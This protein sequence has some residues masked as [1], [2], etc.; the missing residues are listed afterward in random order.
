MSLFSRITNRALKAMIRPVVGSWTDALARFNT[1][2]ETNYNPLRGLTITQAVSYLEAYNRGDM[3]TLQWLY[4]HIEQT[5]ADLMALIERR[6]SAILEMD[7]DTKITPATRRGQDW[8]ETL[9][10]EQ[11]AA[12]LE[13]YNRIDNLYEAIEHLAMASFRGFAHCEMQTNGTQ[14]VNH[15]EIVDQWNVVRDGFRGDWKYNP[16][17]AA[18]NFQ[19][20]TDQPVLPMDQFLYRQVARPIDRIA[21]I[22]FI[23]MSMAEK[24]WT[25]FLEIYGIPSGVVIL[26]P[27]FAP[28]K[29]DEYRD[30]AKQIAEGGSGALP[31]GSDYK[32]ND[33]PRGV[34]PFRAYLDYLSE[35]LVLAGTGGMLTMLTQSG[36][37][38]L[39]GGAHTETFQAIAKS[40][41]RKI[42]EILQRQLDREI[43][44]DDFAGRPVLAYTELDF[45][46]ETDTGAI[47]DQAQK[48]SAA[49]YTI[50]ADELSELTGFTLEI[51]APPPSPF[52]AS[53]FGAP[54]P[55]G[56][57]RGLSQPAAAANEEEAPPIQNRDT[58]PDADPQ[59]QLATAMVSDLAP[60]TQRLARIMQIADAELLT[61]KLRAFRAELPQLLADINADP[62]AARVLQDTM[63]RAMAAGLTTPQPT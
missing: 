15:L 60:I 1:W 4:H 34:N 8:D 20:L 54:P 23:R 38:T 6:T 63:A 17:S 41:A 36:S 51:K 12:L 30:A 3:A 19:S 16:N 29:E 25:A 11:Q 9:A 50:A 7:Y 44:S 56:P 59:I 52:G 21:L 13:G 28:G 22:K 5:D 46:Q 45:K 40:E 33:G 14:F 39:A 49:G 55:G 26:P 43:L 42:G 32:A 57:E 24:D 61:E 31:N 35:K 37:G 62:D 10:A 48:L 58:P 18:T 47:V 2:R 27:S 53:P